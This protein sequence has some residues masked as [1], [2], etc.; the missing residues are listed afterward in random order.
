MKQQCPFIPN[1]QV[2]KK[3]TSKLTNVSEKRE[4]ISQSRKAIEDYLS[5]K[6]A[7]KDPV[8]GQEFFKPVT[9]RPPKGVIF[10]IESDK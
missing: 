8:T 1:T 9:G 3:V 7:T 5:S 2:T 10:Y 6:N 4:K